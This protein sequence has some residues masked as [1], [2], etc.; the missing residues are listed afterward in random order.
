MSETMS[1]YK[2]LLSIQTELK[3]PKNQY[4]SFGDYNYRNCE[5]ILEALKPLLNKYN[6]TVILSDDLIQSGERTYIKAIVKF[7]CI[8]SGQIIETTAQAREADSKK[9]MDLMQLSGA[10]SSYARKYA[11]NGMFCIDD[12]KDSDS[13]NNGSENRD[14][15]NQQKANNLEKEIRDKLMNIL[16]FAAK[17]DKNKAVELLEKYTSFTGR[18]GKDVPGITDINKLK[19][20]RL[21]TTYGRV[22][23]DYPELYAQVKELYENKM[24]EKKGA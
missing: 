6:A 14:S 1:I 18:D 5:D 21:N 16:Y 24:K 17:K 22:Q 20:K 9:G 19:D 10:T 3:A 7:I 4:N 15:G 13:Q 8:E 2:K 12:N 11:L 23:K